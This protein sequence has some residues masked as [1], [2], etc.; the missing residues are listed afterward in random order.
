MVNVAT[1]RRSALGVGVW[2]IC[3]SS[4]TLPSRLRARTRRRVAL[5]C[6]GD[7]QLPGWSY[8]SGCCNRRRFFAGRPNRQKLRQQF[9]PP[10]FIQRNR[11]G[12]VIVR[13][14]IVRPC[15][16]PD[17]SVAPFTRLLDGDHFRRRNGGA[18]RNLVAKINRLAGRGRSAKAARMTACPT[19]EDFTYLLNLRCVGDPRS[20]VKDFL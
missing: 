11:T 8:S 4:A 16:D 2:F 13:E 6:A 10:V 5:P 18:P 14:L 3:S 12:N 20:G 9:I 19:S 1:V 7:G 15:I 17:R